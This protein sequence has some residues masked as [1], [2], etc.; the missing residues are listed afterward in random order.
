MLETVRAYA[1]DR[2]AEL[3]G[4][5]AVHERHYGHFR[6]LAE[7]HGNERALWGASRK[8]HLAALD[9]DVETCTRRWN[10]RSA[11]PTPRP[12]WPCA[13]RSGGTG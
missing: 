7:R 10:G 6:A 5:P 4:A 8:E 2:F 1:A 3:D 11:R 12:R 9:A 13:A